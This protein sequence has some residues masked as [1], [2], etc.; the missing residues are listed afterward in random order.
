MNRQ[1]PL[2][3]GSEHAANRSPRSSKLVTYAVGLLTILA[4]VWLLWSGHYDSPL[5]LGLGGVSL[6]L[7][8]FIAL[9]MRIVDDEGVP[10]Q[11]PLGLVRYVPWLVFE[12]VKA[13]VDVAL[14]I[15]R[16]GLPIRPRVIRVRAGQRTDIGRVIYANSI[17]LTP[18]TVTIDT[19]GDDITVHALTEEA[20]EGVLTGEMDRRVARVE[21]RR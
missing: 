3:S 21:G 14:R 11:L 7:V 2:N 16:P 8:L 13:N 15:L 19:E 20:A 5:L 10:I 9:R 18:G 12:I 17:T 6:A 1:P 4:A